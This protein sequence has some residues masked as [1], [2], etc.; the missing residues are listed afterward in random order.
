MGL[1]G[2]HC[3]IHLPPSP[4]NHSDRFRSSSSTKGKMDE[5]SSRY[6]ILCNRSSLTRP[7]IYASIRFQ[8][9]GC[10]SWRCYLRKFSKDELFDHTGLLDDLPLN[11]NGVLRQSSTVPVALVWLI[12]SRPQKSDEYFDLTGSH[13]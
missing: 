7:V 4:R 11:R 1:P 6:S 10:S 5:G 3:P 9:M 13:G 2:F 8:G 12:K